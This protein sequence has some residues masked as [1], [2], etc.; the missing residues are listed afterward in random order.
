MTNG[1]AS[2]E[3]VEQRRTH[4]I[5]DIEDLGAAYRCKRCGYA[6]ATKVEMWEHRKGFVPQCMRER[7]KQKYHN[8]KK[9]WSV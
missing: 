4:F 3:G 9:K 6:T 5:T 1:A 8:L 2:G 7:I